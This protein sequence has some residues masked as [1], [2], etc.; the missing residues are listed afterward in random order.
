MVKQSPLRTFCFSPSNKPH[1]DLKLNLRLE[2]TQNENR[3]ANITAVAFARQQNCDYFILK[4]YQ[5][6]LFIKGSWISEE[7][8]SSLNILSLTEKKTLFSCFLCWVQA[9]IR[10]CATGHASWAEMKDR[11]L[12]WVL[13]HPNLLMKE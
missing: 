7:N 1:L 9:R 5:E 6:S 11:A 3:P 10:P 13:C 2:T 8:N 12:P 4:N